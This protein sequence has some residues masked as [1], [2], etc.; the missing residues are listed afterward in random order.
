[1]LL[2]S[3]TRPARR[4]RAG[5]ATP[6]R[7]PMPASDTDGAIHTWFDL[8]Y[9]R[10]LVLDPA[11]HARLGEDW[12]Q[13][14]GEMLEQV[15]RAFA[16]QRQ[17]ERYL[18]LPGKQWEYGDLTPELMRE[19]D[20][21]TNMEDLHENC[22]C[23]PEPEGDAELDD[24]SWQR[25]I[26][27]QDRRYDHEREDLRWYDARGDEYQ[28]WMRLTVP[29]EALASAYARAEATPCV[30]VPRS[31]LQS[32]P[33]DWQDRF[34]ALLE[35]VDDDKIA[36]SYDI[37]PQNNIGGRWVDID[38]PVPHYNRGRTYLEPRLDVTA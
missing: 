36:S 25:H 32:M 9:A 5:I 19:L 17:A 18:A 14:I 11:S 2:A 3:P 10:Y 31:F 30:V 23:G 8:T 16:H 15:T 38:D 4:S 6:E 35:Q 20:V 28:R 34:V 24:A 12:H 21:S 37:R 1:M 7:N 29:T 22:D 27:W 13:Q 26:D 33:A